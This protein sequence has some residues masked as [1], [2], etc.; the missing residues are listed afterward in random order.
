MK[1]FKMLRSVHGY[2]EI[3]RESGWK[4]WRKYFI[5]DGKNVQGKQ[6]N[7]LTL[8]IIHM[9]L[10]NFHCWPYP[11]NFITIE[12]FTNYGM[13]CWRIILIWSSLWQNHVISHSHLF[14]VLLPLVI[15]AFQ[16]NWQVQW[17]YEIFKLR[18]S[19]ICN[20][21]PTYSQRC[22]SVNLLNES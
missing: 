16:I 9:K 15:S 19:Q 8:S 21:P 13:L 11:R 20:D 12:T 1:Y 18:K 22:I 6:R 7:C 3:E 14:P 5:V 4:Q 17:L 10:F 2:C